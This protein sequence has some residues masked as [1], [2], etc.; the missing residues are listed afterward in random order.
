MNS[1]LVVTRYKSHITVMLSK[2][3]SLV[4]HYHPQDPPVCSTHND[5]NVLTFD[6]TQWF[7]LFNRNHAN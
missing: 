4:M 7:S 3:L 6:T 5:I 2:L 1:L